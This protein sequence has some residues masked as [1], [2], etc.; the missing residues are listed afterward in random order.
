MKRIRFRKP[1][2][3]P[4][5]RLGDGIAPERERYTCSSP[6]RPAVASQKLHG[7]L[8]ESAWLPGCATVNVEPVGLR[9]SA[10]ECR[11]PMLLHVARPRVCNVRQMDGT[12]RTRCALSGERDR[13]E[14]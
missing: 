2:T 7:L 4:S 11:S 14:R 9:R 12:S 13:Y 1:A 6:W 8:R 10:P 5:K 3:R